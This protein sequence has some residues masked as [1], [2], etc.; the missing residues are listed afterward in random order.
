M[1]SML[2]MQKEIYYLIR[3]RGKWL[4]DELEVLEEDVEFI[5][6]EI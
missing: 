6:G 5:D 1:K 2:D 4:I 3:F